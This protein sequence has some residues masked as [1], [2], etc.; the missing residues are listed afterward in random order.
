MP[1]FPMTVGSTL[2]CFHQAPAPLAPTQTAVLVGVQPAI[3]ATAQIGVIGCLFAPGGVAQP[4]VRIQWPSVS[5]KV[6]VQGQ[7]LLLMPP[8]GTGPSPGI[9]LGPAP[10]GAA[11]MKVNQAQVTAL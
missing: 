1:G 6:L 9:C 5:S 11:I 4:C 8:P 10:Q 3:T 2:S 7:A